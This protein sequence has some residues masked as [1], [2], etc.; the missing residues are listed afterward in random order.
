M[1]KVKSKYKV[2]QVLSYIDYQATDVWGDTI[3]YSAEEVM[4][5]ICYLF[6]MKQNPPDY[7]KDKN[8]TK[9][10]KQND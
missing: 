8:F 10:N 7:Y 5:L 6:G 2:K 9:Y 3:D 4:N 1:K